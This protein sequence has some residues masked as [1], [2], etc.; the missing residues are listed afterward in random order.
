MFTT[1]RTNGDHEDFKFLVSQLD[2]ELAVMDGDEH[3]FYHQFNGITNIAHAVVIYHNDQAVGCGAIKFIRDKVLEVKRMYVL[4]TN[5]NQGVAG[6]ILQALEKWAMDLGCFQ[7]VLET[8]K[9]QQAAIALY[10]KHGFKIIPNYDQYKDV[11]N[12]LCFSKSL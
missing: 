2:H 3:E 1:I 5:R 7:L 8:G 4:P 11:E 12:S 10:K 6:Q 9:N